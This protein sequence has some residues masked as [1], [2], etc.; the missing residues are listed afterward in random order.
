MFAAFFE[1]L[2]V[3]VVTKSVARPE[4]AINV[5]TSLKELFLTSLSL[6]RDGVRPSNFPF[7]CPEVKGAVVK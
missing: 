1:V 2:A 7:R 5:A 3:A 4:A 6:R